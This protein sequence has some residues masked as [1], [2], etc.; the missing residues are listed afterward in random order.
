MKSEEKWIPFEE[1]KT[2]HEF[3][4]RS[5]K[6]KFLNS[7]DMQIEINNHSS[8][9]NS[10]LFGKINYFAKSTFNK[11]STRKNWKLEV[12]LKKSSS[13]KE[14]DYICGIA[15]SRPQRPTIFVKKMAEEC[16]DA[17][18]NSLSTIT[19][20]MNRDKFSWNRNLSPGPAI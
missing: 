20:S 9:E 19:R 17:I 6:E 16:N 7:E 8:M 18:K 11:F 4:K 12:W 15:L 3:K 5:I 10:K 1:T 2:Y 13:R 14:S